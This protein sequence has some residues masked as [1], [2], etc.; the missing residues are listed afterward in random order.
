LSDTGTGALILLA[1]DD[2]DQREVTAD[3]LEFEG[4]RVLPAAQ[5]SEVLEG[6]LQT[7]DLV[8]MDLVGVASPAVMRVLRALPRRPGLLLVSGDSALASVAV[9][10]GADGYLM[11]PYDLDDLLAHIHRVLALARD[12][13]A[14]AGAAESDGACAGA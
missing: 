10:L 1:E 11:K 4:F 7:P 8:L 3:A 5:P 14:A 9:Q 13:S 6:L 12:G 2:D